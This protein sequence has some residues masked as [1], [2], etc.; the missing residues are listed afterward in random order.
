MVHGNVMTFAVL[1]LKI[2]PVFRE[3]ATEQIVPANGGLLFQESLVSGG[4]GCRVDMFV[5]KESE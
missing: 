5:V 3:F 4:I 2:S 1:L